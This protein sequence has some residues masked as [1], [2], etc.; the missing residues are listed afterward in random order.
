MS[1]KPPERYAKWSRTGT[2]VWEGTLD[3]NLWL[4]AIG[5]HETHS[6]KLCD[7]HGQEFAHGFSLHSWDAAFE[8][9]VQ[10]IKDTI[11][12]LDGA[13]KDIGRLLEEGR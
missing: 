13:A 7:D 6:V 8:E 3:G 11:R 9:M 2:D 1:E 12:S 10:D 5:D 4:V